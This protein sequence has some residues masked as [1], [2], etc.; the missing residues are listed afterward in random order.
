VPAPSFAFAYVYPGLVQGVFV[1]G[2]TD[3]LRSAF[4]RSALV[5]VHGWQSGPAV[6]TA[7]DHLARRFLAGRAEVLVF[8]DTDMAFTAEH[9]AEL[10]EATR[11]AGVV[12]CSYVGVAPS[13]GEPY[14]EAA[15]LDAKGNLRPIALLPADA[16]LVEV[17]AVGAGLMAIRREVLEAVKEVT[18][19]SPNPGLRDVIQAGYGEPLPW[20][21]MTVRCGWAIGED[22]EFC[23]RA[24]EA[25]HRVVVAAGV[26]VPHMKT[27]GLLPDTLPHTT[28]GETG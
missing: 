11:E 9:V 14:Q 1:V 4:G 7:R 10:L 12:G 2:L 3:L 17:D 19:Q 8:A 23:L 28:N 5:D 21:A 20:F 6:A 13:S 24:R 25:G 22:Y 26:R 27:V 16:G 18:R 15:R